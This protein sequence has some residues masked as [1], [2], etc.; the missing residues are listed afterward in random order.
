MGG[1]CTPIGV[2]PYVLEAEQV[3]GRRR[4]PTGDWRARF[5]V[6]RAPGGRDGA[7]VTWARKRDR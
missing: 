1:I 3:R 2:P 5:C 7:L 4:I 6:T